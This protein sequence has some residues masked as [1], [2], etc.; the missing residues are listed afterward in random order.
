LDMKREL[1]S[2]GFEISDDPKHRKA[3]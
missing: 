2:Y 3:S 1:A